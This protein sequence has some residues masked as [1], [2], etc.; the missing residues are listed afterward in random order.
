MH[1]ASLFPSPEN[2]SSADE[3]KFTEDCA[4]YI[5]NYPPNNIQFI[6]EDPPKIGFPAVYVTVCT[7][8][9]SNLHTFDFSNVNLLWNKLV[10]RYDYPK[11]YFKSFYG[12]PRLLQ[13]L[14]FCMKEFDYAWGLY[15]GLCMVS[16]G[17]SLRDNYTFYPG[18]I[19][20]VRP[21]LLHRMYQLHTEYG[22]T[23]ERL[24]SRFEEMARFY[25]QRLEPVQTHRRN[26]LSH[27]VSGGIEGLGRLFDE[28][29]R[30]DMDRIRMGHDSGFFLRSIVN[31]ALQDRSDALNKFADLP[32]SEE[33]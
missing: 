29:R 16:D 25:E 22:T 26:F 6:A 31:P 15:M 3:N 32:S 7:D 27:V 28:L 2:S 4:P 20:Q 19:V 12:I 21:E 30:S 8:T 13:R 11:L 5:I 33:E 9:D 23:L 10:F 24:F 18:G 17:F 1:P 14:Y